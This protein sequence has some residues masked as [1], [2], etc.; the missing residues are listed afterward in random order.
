MPKPVLSA[1]LARVRRATRP[2]SEDLNLADGRLLRRCVP[3]LDVQAVA[4][5]QS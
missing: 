3:S 2:R 1:A 5:L 4:V